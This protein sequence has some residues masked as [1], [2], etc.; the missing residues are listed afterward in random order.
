MTAALRRAF[1]WTIAIAAAAALLSGGSFVS[2]DPDS[3]V[4]SEISALMAERPLSA[5]IAPEWWG[6]A[7]ADEPFREHPFGVLVLPAA[8]AWFGYPAQQAGYAVGALYSALVILLAGLVAGTVAGPR[9]RAAVQWALLVLPIAFVYRVRANQEYPVLLLLLL[10]VYGTARARRSPWWI[11]VPPIATVGILLVKDVFFVFAPI[12][13]ALWLLSVRDAEGK[14]SRGWWAVGLS[15]AAAAAGSVL[16]EA[17][18]RAITG[19][20]F[21]TFFLRFRLTPNSGLDRETGAA[22]MVM[23][24]L[25]NVAWYLARLAWFSFP[26]SVLLLF[27]VRRPVRSTPDRT[28]AEHGAAAFGLLVAAVYV[29]LMSLGN[30]RADRFIFP[31]YFAV[32]A[33]GAAAAVRRWAPLQRLADRAAALGAPGT[34]LAWLSLFVLTLGLSHQLPR[35]ELWP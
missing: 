27:Q 35:I 10:G 17:T 32:G 29:G 14:D 23:L 26:W 19:E 21:I 7:G 15:L 8:L 22:R 20:S 25:S 34:A 6:V 3:R 24:W 2:R 18:Y 28:V 33:I 31:A 4:Y 1:V 30:N 11:A 13:C 9:E 12:A 5:W 16:F